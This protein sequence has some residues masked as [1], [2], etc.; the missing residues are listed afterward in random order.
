MTTPTPT[1]RD[2]LVER[3]EAYRAYLDMPT[4][5]VEPEPLYPLLRDCRDALRRREADAVDGAL[6]A[7]LEFWIA[8]MDRPRNPWEDGVLNMFELC[9]DYIQRRST[10]A[11]AAREGDKGCPVHADCGAPPTEGGDEDPFGPVNLN[12]EEPDPLPTPTPREAVDVERLIEA[13]SRWQRWDATFQP[14]DG[15]EEHL[16]HDLEGAEAR[17]GM[18]LALA[19]LSHHPHD[20]KESK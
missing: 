12:K 6:A 1:D 17:Q 9:L 14:R 10:P 7:D 20:T 11:P 5:P 13:V 19:A 16:A 18:R 2:E 8:R 3:I 4:D 15:S